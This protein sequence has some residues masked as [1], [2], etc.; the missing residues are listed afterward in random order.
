[1]GAHRDEPVVE[2]DLHAR[3]RV[4]ERRRARFALTP[5]AARAEDSN[6]RKRRDDR[7][8]RPR[9]HRVNAVHQS[10]SKQLSTAV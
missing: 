8:R 6:A 3:I 2:P 4:H 1:M 9:S 10:S 5:L 7:G